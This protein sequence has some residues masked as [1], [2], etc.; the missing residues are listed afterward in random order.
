MTLQILPSFAAESGSWSDSSSSSWSDNS[1]SDTNSDSTQSQDDNWAAEQGHYQADNNWAAAQGDANPIMYATGGQGS[2]G[3][4]SG[5]SGSHQG[6]QGIG[7]QVVNGQVNMNTIWSSN[8]LDL[9]NVDGDA[10]GTASAVGNTATIITMQDSHV[11][12]NQIQTGN[13][14]AEVNANTWNVHG[15]VMLSATSLCNGVSVSTDPLVTAVHSNQQCGGDDPSASITANVNGVGGNAVM[16]AMSV[17]NQIEVDS[18]AANFP[19]TNYQANTAATIAN[20]NA[21][22]AN[23]HGS[24]QSTSTAVGNTAQIIHY[25]TE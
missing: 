3:G 8:T 12:N 7:A 9:V 19:V 21:N 10:I 6:S 11:E 16:A 4:Q 13:I 17:G 23:V 22:V 18:N 2:W 20:V 1:G 25:T 15:D 14:G 24:I 5:W